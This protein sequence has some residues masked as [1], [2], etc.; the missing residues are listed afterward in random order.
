[1]YSM[2]RCPVTEE[3]EVKKAKAT[4]RSRSVAANQPSIAD[5]FAKRY[6]Q[7]Q[8]SSLALYQTFQ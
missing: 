2:M 7:T 8:P 4:R 3:S 5:L 1:M 6:I